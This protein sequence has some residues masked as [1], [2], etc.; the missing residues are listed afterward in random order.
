MPAG[1][2]SARL[3]ESPCTYLRAP[4]AKR[5]CFLVA[6]A[7]CL[8]GSMKKKH[9]LLKKAFTSVTIMVIPHDSG[10]ALN[11][12]L[13]LAGLIM[14]AMLAVIGG[15]YV[16]G[17]AVSGL[18]YKAQHGEMT[19]EVKYYSGQFYQWASTV[20]SLKTVENRFR[21]LF[22]LKSKDEILE[23][24]DPISVGSMEVPNLISELKKTIESVDEIKNYLRV[25]KDFYVATPK[26]YPVPGVI[27]SHF[28]KRSDP[29]NGEAAIHTGIDIS[30]PIR[31]QI[32][33]TADG[34][35]SH[36]GWIENSGYVV[37]L[38]HGCGFSTVYAHNTTN[39]VKVGQKVK[40]GDLLGYVGITGK[41]TGPHLHYEV[42]KNGRAINA[43]KY[44]PGERDV[45]QGNG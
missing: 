9:L 30:C 11:L 22:S 37:I 5:S 20:E 6:E 41:S 3:A 12:K 29:F 42:W 33:A 10:T 43:E 1:K 45:R 19:A 7:N 26:G 4:E 39:T 16:F 44:L 35:V 18:K 34:V 38:E 21:Q 40:R 17:L 28:G 23:N 13:P 24:A 2:L 32:R 27:T 36:S 8:G 14:S 31:T 25:Q 15:G